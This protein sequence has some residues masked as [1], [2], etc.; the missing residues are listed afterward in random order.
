MYE[1]IDFGEYEH[2]DPKEFSITGNGEM[3]MDDY[4]FLHHIFCKAK[5][6]NVVEIGVSAGGT[7]V[8]LRS[9]MEKYSGENLY[10]FDY[11]VRYYKDSSLPAGYMA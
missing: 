3:S 11:N 1:M 8:F 9:L 6:K 10:S 7:T 5:P 2:F 4:E